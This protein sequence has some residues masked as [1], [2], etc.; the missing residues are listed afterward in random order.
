MYNTERRGFEE[1][2]SN[3]DL[4]V[5]L[6]QIVIVKDKGILFAETVIRELGQN[7]E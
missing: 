4:N 5:N 6:N 3:K 1:L 2:E 7:Y